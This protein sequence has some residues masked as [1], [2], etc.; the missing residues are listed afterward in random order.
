MPSRKVEV[1]EY[2]C[3]KC[4]HK[5]INR[6]NGKE[7]QNLEDVPNAKDGIGKKDTYLVYKNN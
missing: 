4:L 3:A 6:I 7:V 1:T 5:W 2:E